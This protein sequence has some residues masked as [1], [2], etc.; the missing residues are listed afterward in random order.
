MSEFIYAN[1]PPYNQRGR[2]RD[3][4]NDRDGIL[5]SSGSGRETFASI[6]EEADRYLAALIIGIDRSAPPKSGKG[7][8]RPPPGAPPSAEGGPPS[9][10]GG[11]RGSL[12]PGV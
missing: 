12:V 8:P 7:R 6:K 10:E 5:Q 1:V 9:P 11:R 3:T 4:T 2:E